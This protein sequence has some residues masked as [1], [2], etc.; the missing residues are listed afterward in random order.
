[1]NSRGSGDLLPLLVGM[2]VIINWNSDE[3]LNAAFYTLAGKVDDASVLI[4]TT[5]VYAFN[6]H[7]ISSIKLMD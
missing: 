6:H 3:I 7:H 5:D 4:N 1:M 2:Y